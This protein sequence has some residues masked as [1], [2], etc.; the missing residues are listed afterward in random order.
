MELPTME[1]PTME[2]PTMERA[3]NINYALHS[4][5]DPENPLEGARFDPEAEIPGLVDMP[6]I[7]VGFMPI[8]TTVYEES[9]PT[10]TTKGDRLVC[11]KKL[12]LLE[13]F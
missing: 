5:P 1:L 11:N 7:A 9:K 6:P 3:H 12:I 10:D 2:L 4:V 8:V 13:V